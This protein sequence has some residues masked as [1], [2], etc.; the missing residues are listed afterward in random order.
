MREKTGRRCL[1]KA[2]IAFVALTAVPEEQKKVV[3]DCLFRLYTCR[4]AQVKQFN[5]VTLLAYLLLPH[6]IRHTQALKNDLY[7]QQCIEPAALSADVFP[8]AVQPAPHC[9]TV[10]TI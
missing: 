7:L 2:V 3:R 8:A 1:N 6:L 9:F 5:S 10:H 4:Y